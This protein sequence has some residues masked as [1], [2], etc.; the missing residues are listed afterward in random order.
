MGNTGQLPCQA[1]GPAE[2]QRIVEEAPDVR[3]VICLN[4]T[5]EALMMLSC[6][7]QRA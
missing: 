6:V 2:V 1:D 5:A 4:G 3:S 7:S